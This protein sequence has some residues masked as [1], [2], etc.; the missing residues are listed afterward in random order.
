ML[1]Q[2]RGV[3]LDLKNKT[4]IVSDKFLNAVM[5]YYFPEIF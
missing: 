2:P 1:K 5:T 4:V 3:D